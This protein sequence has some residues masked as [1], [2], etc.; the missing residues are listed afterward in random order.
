M[1][2]L[3]VINCGDVHPPFL[4]KSL[5]P[6]W[7]S[8]NLGRSAV[9]SSSVYSL[10]FKLIPVATELEFDTRL[11]SIRLDSVRG[12]L[13]TDIQEPG[14]PTVSTRHTRRGKRRYLILSLLVHTL[15]QHSIPTRH[16]NC[17]HYPAPLLL[18]ILPLTGR[19][20]LHYS[21]HPRLLKCRPGRSYPYQGS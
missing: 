18:F 13:P 14:G 21:R 17:N 16:I 15:P 8:V 10:L 7:N 3:L 2:V 12:L 5:R 20:T 11:L 4:T 9:N 19:R 6:P 1:W